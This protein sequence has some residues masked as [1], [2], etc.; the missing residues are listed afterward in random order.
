MIYIGLDL[1]QAAD[2]TAQA[3]I[4]YVSI[5]SGPMSNQVTDLYMDLVKLARF[6]L[7][8]SYPSIIDAIKEFVVSEPFCLPGNKFRDY[9]LIVDGTGVGRPVIDLCRRAGLQVVPVTIT[10]GT[11]EKFDQITGYWNV[12]KA[13][14]VTNT[15]SG[16][17][18]ASCV[19]PRTSRKRRYLRTS[20]LTSR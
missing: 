17:R 20:W 2:F 8:T 11:E 6:S 18:L 9:R 19:L 10:G 5:K 4:D 12:G 1:G 3:V 16:L 14:L 13:L 7:G 15:W